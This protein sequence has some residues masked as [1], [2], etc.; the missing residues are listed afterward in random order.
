MKEVLDK[1]KCS[2]C[3]AC[4]SICPKQAITME[5]GKDGFRY[6]VINQEKC[7][8]CGLCKKTC[9]ILN[10]KENK[11]INK[12]YVAY[13]KNEQYSNSSSSG[14]IFPLIANLILEEN[15]IVIGAAFD[16]NNKLNHIAITKK[17]DLIKLKG[18]K[19]LQSNLDNIFKYVKE[20]IKEKK[21]LFVGTPCQVAGL[22]AFIKENDNLI[23]I[24]LVCHGVPSPKL[25]DKYIKE[26]EEKN[27][28]KL[29]KYDFRD[30]CSGWDSYSN[31]ATF[32]NSKYTE[33]QKDNAYMKIFLSDVALRES[34]YDCNFKL[35]NKYSDITLGDFWGV[36]KYYPE[37]YNKKGTSA[38]IVNTEKGKELFSTIKNSLEYKKCNIEEIIEGNPSIKTSSKYNPKREKFFSES[39]YLSVNELSKKYSKKKS[40]L[41]RIKG[42]IK[43]MLKK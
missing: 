21:I 8:D 24:D 7:I 37:M 32:K 36:Q 5:V 43:K 35:G 33:L 27:N 14:G 16:K 23:C 29:L 10:T 4:A 31:T 22:K 19:Y 9:P 39:D 1:N 3:T 41:Q 34:C 26:L 20:N 25:F 30:K 18:S 40:V 11:A 38:I 13:S 17:E 28:D 2:G 12:C 6:P 15:G 42:R